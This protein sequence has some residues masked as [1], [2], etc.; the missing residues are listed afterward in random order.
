MI[1]SGIDMCDFASEDNFNKL[2]EKYKMENPDCQVT[3]YSGNPQEVIDS[4]DVKEY[5][6]P[7]DRTIPKYLAKIGEEDHMRKLFHQGLVYMNPLQYFKNLENT[8]DGRADSDEGA[9]FVAQT[10]KMF[11]GEVEINHPVPLT[12]SNKHINY[13]YVYCLIGADNEEDLKRALKDNIQVMG[14]SCV[15]IHNPKEFLNRCATVM[16]S[17]NINLQWGRVRYYEKNEG[18][19]FLDPWMKEKKFAQQSEF[20][21][22][23]RMKEAGSK[24]ILINSIEDVAEACKIEVRD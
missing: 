21:L 1:D 23:F 16:R 18:S 24:A 17:N 14:G 6:I 2:L 3:V 13:G 12:F 7:V 5:P 4:L 19:Y 9:S 22:Y 10:S 8:G 20:R 15:L 11:I